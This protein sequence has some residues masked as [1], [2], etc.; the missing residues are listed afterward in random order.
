MPSFL[1]RYLF[2]KFL[3]WMVLVFVVLT[4][5]GLYAAT[6]YLQRKSLD[7]L[8]ARVGNHSGRIAAALGRHEGSALVFVGNDLLGSLMADPAVGCAELRARG[9]SEPILVAPRYVG[10][11]DQPPLQKLSLPAGRNGRMLAVYFSTREVAQA[12]ATNRLATLLVLLAGLSAACLAG[13]LGFRQTVSKPLAQLRTAI[14][15]SA[16]SGKAVFVPSSKKDELGE[17]LAAYNQLQSGL[18]MAHETTEAEIAQRVGEEQKA[19]HAERIAAGL[20]AFQVDVVEM[21][22]QLHENIGQISNVSGRLDQAASGVTRAIGQLEKEGLKSAEESKD[23]AASFGSLAEQISGMASRVRETI[24]AGTTVQDSSTA[25]NQR[26]TDLTRAIDSIA[27]STSLIGKIAQQTNLL[28]LNATI[29]AARA[30]EAGLG[31]AV[32][33]REVKTLS[34]TTTQAATSINLAVA[35]IATELAQTREAIQHF[36]FAS[37]IITDAAAFISEALGR[38]EHAVAEVNRGTESTKQTAASVA[39]SLQDI[40]TL[41]RRSESA[42]LD[43]NGASQA[44]QKVADRLQS[45]VSSLKRDLAA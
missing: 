9:Q 36:D 32:V 4:G 31:F 19:A 45:A 43:V 22:N 23:V 10:C 7:D 29:E 27:E 8:A 38:Q 41:A 40:L 21:V 34:A 30:G 3:A 13:A 16:E 17:V 18:E 1:T 12:A 35:Q 24:D 20:R 25:V 5:L 26:L 33:A 6:D 44:V 2:L 11:K 39:G 15:E 37:E 14:R 28:A 42:A